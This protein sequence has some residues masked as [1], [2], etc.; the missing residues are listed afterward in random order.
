MTL[1]ENDLLL[2]VVCELIVGLIV[3]KQGNVPLP[4]TELCTGVVQELEQPRFMFNIFT[5]NY[6]KPV[7]WGYKSVQKR[8][9]GCWTF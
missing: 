3:R 9:W 7:Q 4:P 1:Q 6:D 5:G 2:D 8:F